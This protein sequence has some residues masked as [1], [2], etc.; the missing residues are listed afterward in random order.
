VFEFV[1]VV[2]LHV[3]MANA[4]NL[5]HGTCSC[6]FGLVLVGHDDAFL[7]VTTDQLL[8]QVVA[9]PLLHLTSACELIT[10][11]WCIWICLDHTLVRYSVELAH[12]G[13]VD[14]LILV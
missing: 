9:I 4:L 1:G 11:P 10:S 12:V 3:L 13:L 6:C 2:S 8:S 5:T 7:G 14:V